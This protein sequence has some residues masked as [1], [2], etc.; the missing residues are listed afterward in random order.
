ML[1]GLF[2]ADNTHRWD[3]WVPEMRLLKL[4]EAGFAKRRAL[5]EAQ[6]KKNRPQPPLSVESLLH[7][8]RARRP[9]R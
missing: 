2:S 6:T 1:A 4:N 3:E 9:S 7:Q 5:L 8:S